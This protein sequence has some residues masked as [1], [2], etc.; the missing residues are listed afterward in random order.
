MEWNDTLQHIRSGEDA[1]TEFK[2]GNAFGFI[3]TEQQIIP[4]ATTQALDLD[5]FRLF[6]QAQG[7]QMEEGPQPGIDNDLKNASVCDWVDQARS[8]GAPRSRNEMMANAMV[9]R[10]LMERRGRGWLLMRRAMREFNGTEPEIINDQDA[11]FVRVTF[12]FAPAVAQRTE[13]STGASQPAV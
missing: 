4:S 8:G 11:R 13:E 3:L 9:V 12:R 1:Q 7:K 6:M 2:R 5:T 10:Q